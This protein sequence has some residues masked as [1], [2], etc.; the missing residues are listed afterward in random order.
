ML[1]VST[2][3]AIAVFGVVVSFTT[4]GQAHIVSPRKCQVYAGLHSI[5]QN[6]TNPRVATARRAK[7]RCRRAVTIHTHTHCVQLP[8]AR[9]I[10]CV[11]GPRYGWEAVA[12]A[13]C[14]SGLNVYARNGEYLGLF[15]MGAGERARWGHDWTARG[16]SRA[17]HRYFVASGSDWSPWT[18]KP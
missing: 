17:A 5:V 1:R 2:L 3:L 9:T 6:P 15:Q 12:V 8:I 4:D 14:E 7:F 10:L 18:C 11:F 16:Q 13:K